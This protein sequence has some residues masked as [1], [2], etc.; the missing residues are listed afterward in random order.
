MNKFLGTDVICQIGILVN[1]IEK[2]G[3]KYAEFFGV[4]LP[5]V[6]HSGKPE[7][8][9]GKYEGEPTVASCLMMFFNLGSMQVELIQPDENPSVW[10]DDLNRKGEGLHHIGFKVKD[11]KNQAQNLEEAGYKVRMAGEYGDASGC[12]HYIE[13]E[14]ALKM[15]IELLEEY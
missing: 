12:F 2:T 7:I 11:S 15:T 13:T 8:V 6:I 1:D 4:D 14:E 3:K 10:R 5:P 9:K